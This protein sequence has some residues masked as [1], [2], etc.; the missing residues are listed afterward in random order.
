MCCL[1]F[2]LIFSVTALCLVEVVLAVRKKEG[3]M[4]NEEK[5]RDEKERFVRWQDYRITQFSFAINL[6]LSFSV[7]ALGFCLTLIKDPTFVPPNGMGYLLRNSAIGLTCSII[8]GS[9]ATFS[10]LWDF[11]CTVIKIRKKYADCRQDAAEIFAKLLGIASWCLFY[12]QLAALA[13]G[14]FCL[15]YILIVANLDKLAK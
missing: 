4:N 9:L 6:F 15:I 8:F 3:N 10:R 13:Y 11:R 14:A 7:A 1:I 12:F 2:I 5:E